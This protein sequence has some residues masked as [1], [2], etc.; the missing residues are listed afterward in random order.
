LHFPKRR[1]VAPFYQESFERSG[2]EPEWIFL[3]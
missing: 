3:F 2:G 1:S